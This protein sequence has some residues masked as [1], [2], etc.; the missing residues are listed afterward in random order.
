M[1]PVLGTALL[2]AL[3]TQSPVHVAKCNVWGPQVSFNDDGVPKSTGGYDLH[4]RFVNDGTQAIRR[5]VFAL[6]D[7]TRV[8]DAGK[9]VPGVT[10]D[11]LL[12]TQPNSADTCSVASVTFADGTRWSPP[13]TQ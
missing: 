10:I 4:V 12:R 13:R 6:N 7:G 1:M 3:T 2:V 9:F 8:V 11:H 5:I